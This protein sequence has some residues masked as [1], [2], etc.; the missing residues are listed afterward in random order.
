MRVCWWKPE[1]SEREEQCN[2]MAG[3]QKMHQAAMRDHLYGV[4]TLNQSRV[5]SYHDNPMPVF[6][7]VGAVS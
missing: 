4:G 5:I 7:F 1:K 3:V 6:L 2:Q